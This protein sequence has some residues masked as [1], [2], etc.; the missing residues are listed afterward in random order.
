[1]RFFEARGSSLS[2]SP[3]R[4]R[5]VFAVTGGYHRYRAAVRTGREWRGVSH[6]PG[7]PCNPRNPRLPWAPWLCQLALSWYN[8]GFFVSLGTFGVIWRPKC[9]II[10]L[11]KANILHEFATFADST[12]KQGPVNRA[13]FSGVASANFDGSLFNLIDFFEIDKYDIYK[14][15]VYMSYIGR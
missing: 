10:L 11:D 9:R 12:R 6:G 13:L 7:I 15:R 14:Y 5:D 2:R 8:G 4:S 1:M 3:P